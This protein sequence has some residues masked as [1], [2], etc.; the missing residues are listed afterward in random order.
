MRPA[1]LLILSLLAACDQDPV[2]ATSPDTSDDATSVPEPDATSIPPT[3]TSLVDATDASADSE[4]ATP[5][6][7]TPAETTPACEQVAGVFHQTGEC[8]QDFGGSYPVQE[9]ACV[10]QEACQIQYARTEFDALFTGEAGA[11]TWSSGD[12]RCRVAF[13]A[14]GFSFEC[15]ENDLDMTCAGTAQR[16][17]S[18]WSKTCCDVVANDCP[19]GQQCRAALI[20][21]YSKPVPACVPTTGAKAR[22]EVCTLDPRTDARTDDCA[23]GLVCRWTEGAERRCQPTCASTSDCSADEV[24]A[25]EEGAM[26]MGHCAKRCD[27]FDVDACGFGQCAPLPSWS[28][29]RQFGLS[30]MCIRAGVAVEGEPCE[31]LTDTSCAAG[32]ACSENFPPS[33]GAQCRRYCGPQN[34]CD[35]GEECATTF[36]GP[37]L[38]GMVDVG[39]C[40]E[41]DVR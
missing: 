35:A 1:A 37:V 4:D 18:P 14:N 5:A 29:D 11:T 23:Q 34:P 17:T 15:T 25:Y 10:T 7:T 36:P 27:V 24:C 3:E 9:L 20:P 33:A 39:T 32:L 13:D 22:G 2:P 8:S 38:P 26:F 31:G 16:I 19:S 6:E 41:K 21:G 40:Y 30:P 28:E 12:D